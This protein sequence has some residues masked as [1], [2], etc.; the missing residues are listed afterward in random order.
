M[1]PILPGRP[2]GQSDFTYGEKMLTTPRSGDLFSVPLPVDLTKRRVY[3]FH[4]AVNSGADW[5]FQATLRMMYG[6]APAAEFPFYGGTSAATPSVVPG[7]LPSILVFDPA[8]QT[9]NCLQVVVAN[10]L[11]GPPAEKALYYCQPFELEITAD[12]AVVAMKAFAN[13]SAIHFFLAIQ[14]RL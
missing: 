11:A 4:F 9:G 3:G 14:S 1:P 13:I 2:V 12:T 5:F 7:S 8:L 10:P 6:G